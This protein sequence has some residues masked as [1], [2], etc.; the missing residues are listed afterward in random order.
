MAKN[1]YTRALKVLKNSQVDE[2]LQILE[3]LPTNNTT[4]MYALTPEINDTETITL[5]PRAA[6]FTQD[7]DGGAGYTGD[8]TTGL[9]LTD[10]TILTIE[11]PGDTS[12][13]LGPMASMWYAWGNFTQIGYIRQSDRKMV[14]LARITGELGSWDGSSNFTSYGQLTLDQAVWFQ[15]TDK[16]NGADND[17]P[18]YRA[19]Y[20]GPPSNVADQYGRYLCVITGTPKPTTETTGSR[21]PPTMGNPNDAGYP[22]GRN[23]NPDS[24]DEDGGILSRSWSSN[25]W[26]ERVLKQCPIAWK[27][28][29]TWVRR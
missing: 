4:S 11:P 8:D 18:N 19:F 28:L 13:I 22:W 21:T 20:P 25:E 23:P 7:G 9:F 2:K 16:L 6:D 12:Y 5:L 1:R 29:E 10:G 26:L 15:G 3:S 17:T 14:N 24:E 27:R